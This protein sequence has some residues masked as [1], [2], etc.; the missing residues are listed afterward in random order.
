MPKIEFRGKTYNSEFEMPPDVRLAYNQEKLVSRP[1]NDLPKAEDIYRQ[2]AP[3]DAKHLPSDES[4]YRP[5]P[6]VVDQMKP[7][8][9]PEPVFGTN[10]FISSILWALLLVVVAFIIMRFLL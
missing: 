2:S 10:R 9:E 8:I 7:T 4:V 6:P 5:S 3:E 1:R